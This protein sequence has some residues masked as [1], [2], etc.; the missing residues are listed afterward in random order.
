MENLF[1]IATREKYRFPYKG[2]IGVED[3]WDLTPAQLD[4]VFKTLNKT[5]KASGDESLLTDSKPDPTTVNMIEIVKCIFT[6]K[7]NEA[8][9]RRQAAE[10]AEKKRRILDAL[11]QKQDEALRNASED[12]LQ[13]MLA[14]LE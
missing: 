10:N 7:K 14:E 3:L 8:A 2:M 11:A 6:V 5:V 4:V 9:A 1:V 13:K 12:D